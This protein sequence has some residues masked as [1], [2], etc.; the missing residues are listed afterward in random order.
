MTQDIKIRLATNDEG[1]I[2]KGFVAATGFKEDY[3][4]WSQIFPFW[5]VA[6]VED[7]IVGCLQV[8]PSRPIGRLEFLY[9]VPEL[10]HKMRG[11]VVWQLVVTGRETLKL[12]GAQL[13]SAMIPFELKSYK[14]LLKRRGA[15]TALS[16]NLMVWR[17]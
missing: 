9:T 15:T 6:I 16:G 5:L 3:L 13:V 1:P 11:L 10:S 12:E 4:D 8:C 17:T 7:E 2:I 14:R